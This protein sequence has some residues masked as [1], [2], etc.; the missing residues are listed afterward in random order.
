MRSFEKQTKK[1][2]NFFVWIQ[3]KISRSPK[4]QLLFC[5]CWGQ[6]VFILF[7]NRAYV[8]QMLAESRQ[9]NKTKKQTKKKKEQLNKI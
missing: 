2:K 3:L 8:N 1:T 6:I 4:I 5:N 7:V 9:K